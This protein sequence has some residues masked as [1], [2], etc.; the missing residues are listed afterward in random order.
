MAKDRIAGLVLLVFSAFFYYQSTL[1][2]VKELT[3]LQATFFPRILLGFIAILA[4]I[5]IIQS[6]LKKEK[7][8]ASSEKKQ[9]QKEW[10]VWVVFALFGL[11]ILALDFVGF[12]IASFL[13]VGIV[14]LIILPEKK[15]IKKHVFSL[16][17]L[18][19]MIIVL[20]IVFERFLSVF[21]PKGIFF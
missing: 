8:V 18:L 20:Q 7:K 2:D 10:I 21:L 11:Y 13:F 12:V 1:I 5:M 15:S 17:G 6:F 3:G 16:S 19:V 14:Y 9:N 4:I